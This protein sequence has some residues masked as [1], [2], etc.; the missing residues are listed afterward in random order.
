MRGALIPVVLLLIY[1]SLVNLFSCDRHIVVG[2]GGGGGEGDGLE[3]RASHTLEVRVKRAREFG[4]FP[5]YICFYV[6][7]KYGWGWEEICIKHLNYL[8]L[9]LFCVSEI[10]VL[11][12]GKL[13]GQEY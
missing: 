7:T 1:I 3:V 11:W 9:F 2:S 13:V 6:P 5:R 8:V 10:A 4:I 12:K